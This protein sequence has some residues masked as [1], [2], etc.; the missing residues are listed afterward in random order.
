MN[1]ADAKMPTCVVD[2]VG[3]GRLP[4]YSPDDLNVVAMDQRIRDL[5]KHCVTLDATL[6]MQTSHYDVLEDDLNVVKLAVEQHTT[7]FRAMEHPRKGAKRISH[8]P[9]VVPR[10]TYPANTFIPPPSVLSSEITN[11]PETPSV[12]V[13]SEQSDETDTMVD[14]NFPSTSTV[15]AVIT[16]YLPAS[17]ERSTGLAP[18][19]SQLA[20]DLK[21]NLA[22]IRTDDLADFQPARK[23]RLKAK[24]VSGKSISGNT[25]KGGPTT[26]NVFLFRVNRDVSEDI[27]KDH[28]NDNISNMYLLKLCL[29]RELFLNRFKSIWRLGITVAL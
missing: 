1:A 7:R 11:H 24:V 13:R 14:I 28:M 22:D 21:L 10:Q 26:H 23:R 2:P 18:S 17:P 27:V 5:E 29:M 9:S 16:Q 6:I 15:T 12:P 20:K 3:I 4:K 25:Y 8:I 19:Y